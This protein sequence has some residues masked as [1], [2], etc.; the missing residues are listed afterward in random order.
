[1][2]IREIFNRDVWIIEED[3]TLYE[4]A[5]MMK[6]HGVGSL[7]VIKS[8]KTSHPVGMLTDRMLAVKSVFEK[9]DIK[10]TPVKKIMSE[11]I[12]VAK[13]NQSLTEILKIMAKKGIR[14]IPITD[15]KNKLIGILALDDIIIYLA[16]QLT[17]IQDVIKKQIP[18]HLNF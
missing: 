8:N 5:K 6:N 1:M 17:L 7:V 12:F 13:E 16:N 2:N 9:T 15:Q 18:E 14:R 11:K 3:K 10:H 4:A